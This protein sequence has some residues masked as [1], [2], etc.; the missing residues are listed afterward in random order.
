MAS[1][2]KNLSSYDEG[3]LPSAEEFTFG[4]VVADWNPEITHALYE[5]CYDTLVKHGAKE[6][7]IH[8]A[9]V[10]GSFELPAG[11]KM[12]IDKHKLD[13]VICLGCVIKGETSHNE[14]I[15]QAVASGLTNLSMVYGKPFI[16]GVLTPNT[17]EQARDRAGGKHGNKGVE[18]AVTAIRMAAL[19]VSLKAAQPRIGFS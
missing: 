19:K 1:A 11:A 15:N 8:T 18:A 12:M 13:A 9:Q 5:G 2:L 3:Q 10:P 17:E 16:F 4:I 7:N 14:Y 6:A